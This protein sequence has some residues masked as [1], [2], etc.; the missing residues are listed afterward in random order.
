MFGSGG[1]LVELLRDVSYRSL[2][3]TADDFRNMVQDTLC[4]KLL[5]GF[6]NQAPADMEAL[7]DLMREAAAVFLANPW[8]KELEFNPVVVLPEEQGVRV[9][10]VALTASEETD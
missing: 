2:P 6:R 8:M 10:D 4:H 5:Q 7:L 9:L 1:I 3:G